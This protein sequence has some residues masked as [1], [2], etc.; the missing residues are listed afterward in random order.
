MHIDREYAGLAFGADRRASN[1]LGQL[2]VRGMK[3]KRSGWQG[4]CLVCRFFVKKDT[5]R[6]EV[7]ILQYMEW[8]PLLG[9]ENETLRCE[10]LQ[11][12]ITD[13]EEN[14]SEL[15]GSA[16]K[17]DCTVTGKRFEAIPFSEYF[18][19]RVCSSGDYSSASAYYRPAA[20]SSSVIHS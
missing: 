10:R 20:N 9:A 15:S 5:K 8:V 1:F 13:D 2:K 11:W 3:R 16:K 6:V 7:K 12:A 18:E 4:H 17:K 14:V 19:Y